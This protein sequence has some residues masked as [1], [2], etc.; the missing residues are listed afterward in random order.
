M[1]D[2]SV[3]ETHISTV[4]FTRERAY[5]LLKPLSTGFLDFSTREARLSAARREL[6]LNRRLAPDV[7]LGLAD[8]RE[9]GELVDH[10]IVMRR[11]PAERRLSTLLSELPADAAPAAGGDEIGRHLRA[12]VRQIAALHLAHPPLRYPDAAVAGRDAVAANWEDNFAAISEYVGPVIDRDEYEVVVDLARDYLATAEPVFEHR[13]ETGWIRDGHGDLRAEDIFCLDDGP[14]I[15]DCLAFRDDLRVG[16][17]IA[18]IGFLAMDIEDMAGPEPARALLSD[19]GEF[20]HEIHPASLAH[21]YIA[22][23]AHVRVKVACLQLEQGDGTKADEAARLHRLAASHLRRARPCVVMVGGAPGS[24]KSTVSA[25]LSRAFG[26]A[27]VSSDEIRK[28]LAG[29]AHTADMSASPGDGIYGAEMKARVYDEMHKR[30]D[31]LL[32]AGT[33][34]VLDASWSSAGMRRPVR[35]L[36]ERFR[37]TL[38][39]IECRVDRQVAKDRVARRPRSSAAASDATPEIVEHLADSAEPWPEAVV[40]DTSPTVEQTIARAVALVDEATDR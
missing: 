3:S 7:Y 17:V 31:A 21:H 40:V 6:E 14:R 28:D 16:D 32:S 2:A 29:V 15:L 12:V 5:K 24:G 19:Y 38:V 30:A 27:Q 25:G 9:S 22:Y 1:P 26:F 39:E 11:L 13:I 10:M 35:D 36:A 33:S 4:F 34:I 20:T 23:R 18:D 8:V 37:A